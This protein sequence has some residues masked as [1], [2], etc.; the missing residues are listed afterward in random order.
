MDDPHVSQN[1]RRIS[2]DKR[3]TVSMKKLEHAY[4]LVKNGMSVKKA[5]NK[6]HQTRA[7]VQAYIN[8]QTSDSEGSED[9]DSDDEEIGAVP[10]QSHSS[11][12]SDVDSDVDSE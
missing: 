4:R 5:A 7:S 1:I 11:S 10:A 9:D 8:Q 2:Y 3:H 6:V 12:G